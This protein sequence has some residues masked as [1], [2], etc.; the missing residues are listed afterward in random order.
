MAAPEVDLLSIGEW[1]AMMTSTAYSGEARVE[2]VI[3]DRHVTIYESTPPWDEPGG[4][5]IQ[6]PIARLRY[7]TK[8]ATWRLYWRDRHQRFHSYEPFPEVDDVMDYLDFLATT[9]DP[10]FWP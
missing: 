8:T 3:A 4:P 7:V 10:I 2:C 5:W 6:F 1:C 9:S